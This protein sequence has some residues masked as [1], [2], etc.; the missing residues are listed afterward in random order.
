MKPKKYTTSIKQQ[1]KEL[2]NSFKNKKIIWV[3]C[4]DILFIL[5][6]GII[7]KTSA[8]LMTGQLE[9]AG[10][11]KTSSLTPE[12]LSQQIGTL[13]SLA[14]IFFIITIIAYIILIIDY[15]LFRGWA[16]TKIFNKKPTKAYMKKFLLLNL[17][18]ITG[19]IILFVLLLNIINPQYYFYL[20]ITAVI[21]YTHLTTVMHYSYTKTNK[22]KTSINK[23]F[24]TGIGKLNKFIIPYLFIIIFY[25]IFTG[26]ITL[27]PKQSQAMAIFS[28]IILF[29][30]WYKTYMN[31]IIKQT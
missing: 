3:L 8:M 22:I 24:A 23:A 26:I 7:L 6:A 18:W 13:K 25:I 14:I 27:I 2:I 15:T 9:K 17:I 12:I 4:Y 11:T 10:L 1:L 31:Q 29:M 20:I 28:I 19:W 5:I 30:A 16:W 21:L